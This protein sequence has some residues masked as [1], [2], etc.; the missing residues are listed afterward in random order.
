[1]LISVEKHK[2]KARARLKQLQVKDEEIDD[3]LSYIED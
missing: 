2:E 3:C 1:M